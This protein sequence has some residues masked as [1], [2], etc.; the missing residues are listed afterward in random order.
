MLFVGSAIPH[1]DNAED[2]YMNKTLERLSEFRPSGGINTFNGAIEKILSECKI[3]SWPVKIE[4]IYHK[5]K[6][7]LVQSKLSDFGEEYA[8][9]RGYI[10]AAD[11]KIAAEKGVSSIIAN[12]EESDPY[13]RRRFTAAHEFSHAILHLLDELKNNEGI[14][15]KTTRDLSEEWMPEERMA[16][17]F[18]A[19]LLM[20]EAMVREAYNSFLIK[21]VRLL[22]KDF[23]VSPVVMKE[24]LDN[25]G[26]AGYFNDVTA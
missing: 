18:A 25:L 12:I 5:F 19:Q 10:I 21:S 14:V 20:P 7:K 23:E 13:E 24:R 8:G 6:I 9:K 17:E 16:N 11:D 3:T 4:E 15:A 22:A 26:L 2:V 1:D